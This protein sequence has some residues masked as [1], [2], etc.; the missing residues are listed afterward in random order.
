MFKESVHSAWVTK[1]SISS[2]PGQAN[3]SFGYWKAKSGTIEIFNLM[4][5]HPETGEELLPVTRDTV[6]QFKLQRAQRR[7]VLLK[8]QSPPKQIDPETY[9]FFDPAT[10]EARGWYRRNNNGVYEFYDNGGFHPQTG[11][12]LKPVDNAILTKW[13]AE[14]KEA[15]ARQAA[16]RSRQEQEAQLQ[17]DRQERQR[18]ALVERERQEAQ[19]G[20]TCDQLAG[21]PSDPHR[22]GEVTGVRYDELRAHATEALQACRVARDKFPDELRYKYQFA[23]ALEIDDPDKAI[24][25]YRQL[26]SKN[27]VAAFDNLG[28]IYMR[29]HDMKTAISV[30]KA[31]V[32][33]N[34]PDSMV[35]LS[36]LVEKGYLPV[37]NPVAAKYALLERAAQLGHSGARIAVDEQKIEIQQRQQEHISQQQ[38]Q[39]MMLEMFGTILRGVGR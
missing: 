25:L 36:N 32:A 29:K 1:K 16:E 4:G 12:Q 19:A 14:K 27:Y 31:G 2:T 37:Q 33:A 30:L 24:P 23:R 7:Q 3:R 20:V 28:S 34:D 8:R 6:E 21:N 38:Q 5:F 39:Q 10:G 15:E 11:E 18:Q 9:V 22:S 26:M 35:T 13:R 17:A